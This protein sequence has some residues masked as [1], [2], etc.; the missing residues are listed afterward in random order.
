MSGPVHRWWNA[1]KPWPLAGARRVALSTAL[2]ASTWLVACASDPLSRL[3]PGD[4]PAVSDATLFSLATADGAWTYYKRSAVPIARQSSAH[5]ERTALV[6]YNAIAAT[7][8]DESGKVRRGASFPDSSLIVK[9][10]SNGNGVATYAIM[11]KLRSSASAG[12]GGWVWGEF[13]PDGAV[14]YSTSG[15]GGGCAGCHDVGIDYTRMN[16]SHP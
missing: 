5:P 2:L 14:R 9:A 1:G 7:Q 16:D 10:L 12:V 8:L 15:R 11:L 3:A 4:G 13:G 6:R